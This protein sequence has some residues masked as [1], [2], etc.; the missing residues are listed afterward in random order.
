LLFA[1]REQ[2]PPQSTSDS[3][4]F[5]SI[6]K[7]VH[8]AATTQTPFEHEGA[9]A[10]PPLEFPQSALVLQCWPALQNL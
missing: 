9:Y 6:L 4:V 1:Q 7:F 3:L 8:S 10:I 5:V 2:V